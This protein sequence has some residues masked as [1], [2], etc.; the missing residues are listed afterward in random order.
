M[1]VYNGQ[2]E[3][4][5]GGRERNGCMLGH[6]TMTSE[7]GI[8]VVTEYWEPLGADAQPWRKSWQGIWQ[9]DSEMYILKRL[10]V[11]YVKHLPHT[12][13]EIWETYE[14]TKDPGDV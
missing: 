8:A 3:K 11:E 10:L 12:I 7:E 14:K 2:W 9:T 4:Q 1:L 6:I 5:W 13:T